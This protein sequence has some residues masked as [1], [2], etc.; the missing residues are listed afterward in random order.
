MDDERDRYGDKL[1]E[2]EKAREDQWAREQDQR[3]LEK[4]R[5]SHTDELHCPKCKAVLAPHVEN[6]HAVFACPTGH[7]AWLDGETVK[8]LA[9]PKHSP[10][11]WT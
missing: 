4:L 5:H 10:R 9:S 1:H 7:G 6:G 2:L 3:L 8:H 11:R